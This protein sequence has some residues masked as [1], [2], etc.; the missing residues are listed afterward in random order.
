M[1]AQPEQRHTQEPWRV[2]AAGDPNKVP[3]IASESGGVAV[4]CVNRMMGEDGPSKTELANAERIVA[5]VNACEGIDSDAFAEMPD[6]RVTGILDMMKTAKTVMRERREEIDALT[7]RCANLG[8]DLDASRLEAATLGLC[9][10]ALE[11][12]LGAFS[13]WRRPTAADWANG[14]T[15]NEFDA[16]Q[17]LARAALAE[18]QS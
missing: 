4:I 5:C 1:S 17:N 18:P 15:Q 3:R 8:A 7:A 10:A 16:M 9:V 11:K 6:G 13:Q 2:L 12:A 14:A